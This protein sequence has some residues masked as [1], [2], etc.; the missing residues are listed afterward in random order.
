MFG[1]DLK[2]GIFRSIHAYRKLCFKFGI[3]RIF[4]RDI[5]IARVS[6]KLRLAI[7]FSFSQKPRKSES[8]GNVIVYFEEGAVK[9]VDERNRRQTSDWFAFILPLFI[10]HIILRSKIFTSA[11]RSYNHHNKF[12]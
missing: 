6:L 3:L 5:V 4:F 10:V 8:D 1:I 11:D 12:I 7:T 2:R 9:T